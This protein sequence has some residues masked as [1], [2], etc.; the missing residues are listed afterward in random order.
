VAKAKEIKAMIEPL[1][2]RLGLPAPAAGM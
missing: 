2:A 1:M